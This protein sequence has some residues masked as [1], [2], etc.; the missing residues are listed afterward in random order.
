M[1]ACQ[2]DG[3][4]CKV[5]T[6]TKIQK[7][8]VMK[9]T[10]TFIALILAVS[11]TQVQQRDQDPETDPARQEEQWRQEI[12]EADRAFSA[13]SMDSGSNIAFLRY[14]APEAVLLREN[15]MPLEGRDEVESLL[16]SRSDSAYQLSWEPMYAHVAGSGDLGYTYGTFRL[17][18]PGM[19]TS[20][21]GT[22]VS[23]WKKFGEDWRWVLDTGNQGLGDAQSDEAN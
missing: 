11:C 8:I 17:D 2:T 19:D 16:F 18:I 12:L 6:L 21:A 13:L 5:R 1:M 20:T 14:A 22:Y 9:A 3:L 7:L 23:I 10:F 15:S 4:Y